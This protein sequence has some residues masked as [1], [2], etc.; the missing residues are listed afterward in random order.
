MPRPPA[1]VRCMLCQHPIADP[2]EAFCHGCHTHICDKHL[3]DP[4]GKHEPED[5]NEDES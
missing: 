4:M 3:A 2:D 5:H 1:L